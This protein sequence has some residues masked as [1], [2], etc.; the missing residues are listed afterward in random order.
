M[1]CQQRGTDSIF[2]AFT[3]FSSNIKGPIK[4]PV[5][6]AVKAAV[7]VLSALACPQC[8]LSLSQLHTADTGDKDPLL[9]LL[10]CLPQFWLP[11]ICISLSL[12]FFYACVCLTLY[13][14]LLSFHHLHSP[15]KGFPPCFLLI[16]LYLFLSVKS[17]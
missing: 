6:L 13:T 5:K 10:A 14:F 17:F 2:V 7:E 8:S 9:N 3:T 4:V 12:C 11:N 15:L 16:F 1:A